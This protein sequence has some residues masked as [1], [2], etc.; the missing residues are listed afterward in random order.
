M[1]VRG[2]RIGTLLP[3]ISHWPVDRLWDNKQLGLT[4]P[5]EHR[6]GWSRVSVWPSSTGGVGLVC[7]QTGMYPDTT[8]VIGII[9]SP[10]N[11]LRVEFRRRFEYQL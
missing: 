4:D 2:A 10:T 7:V 1:V 9:L 8:T 6:D 11:L 3:C 5:G